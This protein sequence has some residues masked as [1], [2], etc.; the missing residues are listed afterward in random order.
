MLLLGAHQCHDSTRISTRDPAEALKTR[1]HQHRSREFQTELPR[2]HKH[3][4]SPQT[5]L[6]P[7]HAGG[8]HERSYQNQDGVRRELLNQQAYET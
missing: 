4:I 5:V 8:M 2:F 3:E 7:G 6:A 1:F